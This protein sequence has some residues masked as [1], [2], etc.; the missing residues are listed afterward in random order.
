MSNKDA[1]RDRLRESAVGS[2]LPCALAHRLAESCAVL[3]QAVGESADAM[4]IRITQCQLGLFGYDAFGEKRWVRCP[5]TVPRE[6]EQAIR[7][8]RVGERLPC[9]T[10]WRLADDRGLP[11]LLMGSVSE[12][13]D[14]RISLCQ[15][16]CF[17]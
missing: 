17:E 10:A 8:A 15:L 5:A 3:P 14:V 6:L 11:R 13:L 1:L 12:T 16:G 2:G 7:A 4:E 9:A